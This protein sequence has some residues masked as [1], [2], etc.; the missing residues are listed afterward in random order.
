MKNKLSEHFTV[1]YLDELWKYC[2]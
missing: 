2:R 1:L